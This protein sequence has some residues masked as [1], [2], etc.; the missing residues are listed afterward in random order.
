MGAVVE[1]VLG[2]RAVRGLPGSGGELLVWARQRSGLPTQD[3]AARF[4]MLAA[5][6]LGERRPTFKQLESY[7]Q[8][9]HTP[10][11]FLFL[12]QP[13][14]RDASNAGDR[15]GFSWIAAT[16]CGFRPA[17]VVHWWRGSVHSLGSLSSLFF[18]VNSRE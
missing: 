5:W 14:R 12:P 17:R 6:E 13:P 15:I 8:A 4:P 11:G 18:E 3:L 7:A 1:A 9:T 16:S 10:I 2:G